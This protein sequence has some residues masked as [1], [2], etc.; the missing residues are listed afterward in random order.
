MF[1][2]SDRYTHENAEIIL[3][4][5]KKVLHSSAWDGTAGRCIK[6]GVLRGCSVRGTS[7]RTG[8]VQTFVDTTV[9]DRCRLV[10]T[11]GTDGKLLVTLR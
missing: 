1:A 3:V 2:N 8:A 9:I 7:V 11:C 10:S 5:Q 6:E 4:G